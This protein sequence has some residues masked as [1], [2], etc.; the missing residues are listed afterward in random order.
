MIRP[1]TQTKEYWVDDFQITEADVEQIYNHLLEVEVPQTTQQLAHIVF[2]HR[3]N[4]E[5]NRL[6]QKMSSRKMYQ[7]KNSYEVGDELIFPALKFKAGVVKAIRDGYN[8]QDGQFDVLQVEINGK[9]REFAATLTQEHVLN[10]TDNHPTEVFD[11]IDVDELLAQFGEAVMA[12]LY[13]KLDSME[14]FVHLAQLWYVKALM[15]DINIGHLHLSEAVL[16]MHEGGAL[17]TDEIMVHLDMD[18]RLKPAAVRFSLDYALLKDERFDEVAPA[19][20]IAWFLRRMQP[21]EVQTPPEK[22]VYEKIHYDNA[23]LGPHLRLLI[24]ELDDEWSDLTALKRDVGKCHLIYPHRL[25]GT[26]PLNARMRSL[27]PLGTSPH[28]QYTLIDRKADEKIPVWVVQEH[29][30]V[31]GLR[32]W[33]KSEGIPIGAE[34]TISKG[35]KADTL[36]LDYERRKGQKEWVRLA[37]VADGQIKFEHKR[38]SVS[39]G[40]DDLLIVGTD[41]IAALD[42]MWRKMS[43]RTLAKL[44]AIVLPPLAELNPQNTVH[45][46]TLYSA[47]NMLRRVPPEPLFAELVRHPAFEAVGDDYWRFNHQRWQGE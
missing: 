25:E 19:E 21:D 38:R 31:Y 3:V 24:Q 33:Y 32:D 43:T 20:E 35:P 12:T 27:F 44:I 1:Q 17:S 5:R 30:Y 16:E 29:R 34:I 37:S 36:Y 39:A 18:P 10:L 41:F 47:I 7:P 14:D 23:L 28:Q 26:L 11:E 8:P 40:F 46:K 22:L 15:V 13:E 45:S 2:T 42:M 9:E 6:A 4:E